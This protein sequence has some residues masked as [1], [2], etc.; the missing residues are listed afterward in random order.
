MQGIVI[1]TIL[2]VLLRII[3]EFG[4]KT[5]RQ[6]KKGKNR[7]IAVEKTKV[8]YSQ[9]REP[10]EQIIIEQIPIEDDEEE[11]VDIDKILSTNMNKK[12]ITVGTVNPKK[13][14]FIDRLIEVF[15]TEE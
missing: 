2:Y 9:P 1:V 3:E 14:Y 10:I 8:D 5:L 7:G 12:E 4:K 11:I 15:S 6:W 13:T